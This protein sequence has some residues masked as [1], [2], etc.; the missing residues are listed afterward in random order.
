MILNALSYLKI[1]S[2][3]GV[4]YCYANTFILI[5]SDFYRN[6]IIPLNAIIILVLGIVFPLALGMLLVMGKRKNKL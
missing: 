2:V 4:K 1:R 5:D 3:N 6:E